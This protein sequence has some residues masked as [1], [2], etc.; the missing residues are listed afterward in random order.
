M[1]KNKIITLIITL[2]IILIIIGL[3]IIIINRSI[4]AGA[5]TIGLA[6]NITYN[7]IIVVLCGPEIRRIV[8]E[9]E[10]FCLI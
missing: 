6:E 7:C 3:S 2:I 8:K 4:G 9:R 1:L 10:D 5:N